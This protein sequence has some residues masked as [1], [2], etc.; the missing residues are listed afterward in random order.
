MHFWSIRQDLANKQLKIKQFSSYDLSSFVYAT[1][2]ERLHEIVLNC[3]QK[4]KL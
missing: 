2:G 4:G 3:R 1:L